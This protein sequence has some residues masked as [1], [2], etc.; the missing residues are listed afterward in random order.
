[1]RTV[2][3]LFRAR[4]Q[5]GLTLIEM[6]TVIGIIVFLAA[7]IGGASYALLRGGQRTATENLFE[8]IAHGLDMYRVEHRMYVPG[9]PANTYDASS[10]PLW[11]ALEREGHHVEIPG[12]FKLKES[13]ATDLATG[14]TID[15]FIYIDGWKKPLRYECDRPW[16]KYRLESAGPDRKW[17]TADD[18]KRE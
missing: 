18:L 5:M 3:H 7:A 1:M 8:H 17:G 6:L 14:E 2:P 16:Q 13:R 10:R 9:D 11:Y 15:F 12:K 4:A